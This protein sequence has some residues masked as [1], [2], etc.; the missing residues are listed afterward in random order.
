VVFTVDGST[1]LRAPL[2][3]CLQ[4]MHWLAAGSL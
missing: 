4:S 2:K 3:A 1:T